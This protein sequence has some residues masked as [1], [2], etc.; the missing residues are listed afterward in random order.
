[1]EVREP[2]E[3]PLEVYL[4]CCDES[5]PPRFQNRLKSF[6]PRRLYQMAGNWQVLTA[7]RRWKAGLEVNEHRILT[8]NVYIY[9]VP[10]TV[11]FMFPVNDSWCNT[12]SELKYLGGRQIEPRAG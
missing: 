7:S 1:M 4:R 5:E 8:V 12:D 3:V 6:F 10:F 11:I 2:E 9:D